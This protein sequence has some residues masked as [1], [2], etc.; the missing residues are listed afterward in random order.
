[1]MMI[2]TGVGVDY[3]KNH[4]KVG[5]DNHNMVELSELI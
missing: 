5:N 1:M 3:N 2:V 4:W